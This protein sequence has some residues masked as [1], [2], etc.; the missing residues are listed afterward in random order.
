MDDGKLTSSWASAFFSRSNQTDS[1]ALRNSL[2]AT[3]WLTHS[4]LVA[5]NCK[6]NTSKFTCNQKVFITC[7]YTVDSWFLEPLIFILLNNLNQKLFPSRRSNNVVLP[8]ISWTI[9]FFKPIF[10]S[11]EGLNIRIT[12]YF[13]NDNILTRPKN[14][15]KFSCKRDLSAFVCEHPCFWVLCNIFLGNV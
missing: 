11:L 2:T 4:R 9:Q 8:L 1:S 15:E 7:H 12:L 10:I 6:W 14:C 13:Q 3:S 5:F